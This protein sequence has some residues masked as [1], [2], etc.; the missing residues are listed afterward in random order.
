DRDSARLCLFHRGWGDPHIVLLVLSERD[1]RL[2]EHDRLYLGVLFHGRQRE[3]ARLT[4]PY[5]TDGTHFLSQLKMLDEI[6]DP[7]YGVRVSFT[8]HGKTMEPTESARFQRSPEERVLRRVTEQQGHVDL[9][10]CGEFIAE[11]NAA[12][13]QPVYFM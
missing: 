10:L 3:G 1:R 7:A 8:A 5:D 11:I 13:R 6:G 4:H 9:K 2:A 12:G